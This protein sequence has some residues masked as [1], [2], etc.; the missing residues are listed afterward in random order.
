MPHS[1]IPG[2]PCGPE[3][4]RIRT[5]IGI[6][7][8]I[9]VFDSCRHVVVIIEHHCPSGVLQQLRIG[10][11][12]LDYGAIRRKIAAHHDQATFAAC[13][14]SSGVW[15]TSALL[16]IFA[17]ATCSR[18]AFFLCRLARQGQAASAHSFQQCGQATC[19]IESLPSDT[20]PDGRMFTRYGAFCA[21]FLRNV[22]VEYLIPARPAS[23]MT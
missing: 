2:P 11:G 15:I 19:V 5:R 22:R 13:I 18:P 14:G 12:G 4:R 7:V 17:P 6:D 3:L 23:A 9:G 21:R 16:C 8:Q 20:F 1:G 10:C